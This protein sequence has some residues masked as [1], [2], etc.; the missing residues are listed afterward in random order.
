MNTVTEAPNE[1]KRSGVPGTLR[2][3]RGFCAEHGL[4]TADV[5]ARMGVCRERVAQLLFER[6][7]AS[8]AVMERLRAAV[9]A[10]AQRKYLS[11]RS[12]DDKRGSQ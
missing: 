11:G 1:V 5:A 10:A 4:R 7:P 6:R 3:L 2:K 9:W 12:E 8:P